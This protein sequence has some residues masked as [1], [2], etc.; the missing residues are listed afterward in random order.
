MRISKFP[1]LV[2]V[3]ALGAVGCAT[4]DGGPT[5]TTIPP[6][7]FVRFINAVPDTLNATVR[8]VDYLEFTPQ[9]FVNVPYRGVGQGLYQGLK[10]GSRHF[11]I[12]TADVVNFSVA[13]NTAVLGDVTANFEANK[14]YTILLTGYAR[15]GSAPAKTVK[16]IED[17][18][19]A[20][21]TNVS[22]RALNPGLGQGALDFHIVATTTTPITT[23]TFSAVAEGAYSAYAS[24]AP[25]AFAVRT[26]AAGSATVL[27]STNAPAGVA[28]TTSADPIGGATVGGS[29][30]TAIAFPAAVSGSLAAASASPSVVYVVDKQ[31]PRTTSP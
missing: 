3:L 29:I 30:I 26:A 23:P 5:T 31:P 15:A 24:I 2:A 22:I 12:F 19:P 17:V 1:M 27:A 18:L 25:A 20:Q 4:N 14:Y 21:G 9:T 7:A 13:G 16:I 10:A 11:T 28:G 8:W 6:V